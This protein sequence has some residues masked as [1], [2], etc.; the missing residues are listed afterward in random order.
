MSEQSGCEKSIAANGDRKLAAPIIPS[1]FSAMRYRA[2]VSDDGRT[3]PLPRHPV[4]L[5]AHLI[6]LSEWHRHRASRQCLTG[7]YEALAG[8]LILAKRAAML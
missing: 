4:E 2:D 6:R 8:I 1:D 3:G 5:P 7:D